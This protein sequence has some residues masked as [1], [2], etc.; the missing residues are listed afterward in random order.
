MA[1]T[2]DWNSKVINVPKTF[3][4]LVTAGPPPV[5]ELDINE[6]RQALNDLQDS[7]E[8]MVYPTTHNHTPETSLSG[9]VFSRVVEIV[10]GYTITF[11]D[12]QYAVNLV[13]ANSNI[14]DV[15]NVNQV[16]IRAFNTAGLVTGSGGGG[17]SAPSAE[18]NAEML[19]DLPDAVENNLTVRQALRLV[20]AVLA[21]ELSGADTN[22]VTIKDG[23]QNDITRVTATVDE[24]G[25]RTAVD[26]D[27]D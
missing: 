15:T 26:V 19:L 13:G 17:G 11:E 22:T 25:N 21:G 12:G 7:E 18:D 8:G 27:L 10:N 23:G 3:L 14:S 5:Y 9:T 24:D 16:S 1:I 2:I 4:S 6:F 20:A